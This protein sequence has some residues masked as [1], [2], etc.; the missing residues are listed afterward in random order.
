MAKLMECLQEEHEVEV[1]GQDTDTKACKKRLAK[2]AECL[3]DGKL[4]RRQSV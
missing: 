1:V 2:A 4:Q 3:W